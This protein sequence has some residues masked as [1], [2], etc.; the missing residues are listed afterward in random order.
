MFLL[1]V[2]CCCCFVNRER[3]MERVD[4]DGCGRGRCERKAC[5]ARFIFFLFENQF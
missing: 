2:S 4:D 1:V 5:V 3:W